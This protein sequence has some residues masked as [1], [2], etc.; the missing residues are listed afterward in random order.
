MVAGC[1]SREWGLYSPREVLV[2]SGPGVQQAAEIEMLCK[3]D[4]P[5]PVFIQEPQGWVYVGSYR[6]GQWTQDSTALAAYAQEAG[7]EDSLTRVL[8]LVRA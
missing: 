6:V 7:R 3:Q 4:G 1:F 2:G 5:I 8:F